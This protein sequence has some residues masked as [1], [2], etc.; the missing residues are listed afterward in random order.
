MPIVQAHSDLH[1]SPQKLSKIETLRL[2]RNY[3]LA[4]AQTLQEGKPM[5]LMRFVKILSRELSQT[6]A[7]LLNG[8]LIGP[9]GNRLA[10]YREYLTGE[11]GDNYIQNQQNILPNSYNN[12]EWHDYCVNTNFVNSEYSSWC[13]NNYRCDSYKHS[14]NYL[15][16]PASSDFKV[17]FASNNSVDTNSCKYDNCHAKPLFVVEY[18]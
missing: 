4:L 6:T 12:P 13:S 17:V 5:E 16:K 10:T 1:S 3:I 11:F 2:A 15:N 18:G 8:T 9:L 7:N 14:A